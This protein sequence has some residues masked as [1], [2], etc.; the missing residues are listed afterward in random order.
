MRHRW[1][2][3][4]FTLVLFSMI[5]IPAVAS[6]SMTGGCTGSVVIDGVT[7]GPENDTTANPIVVPIDQSGV[8]A[9]WQ[10]AVPFQN[11]ND[12][13]SLGIVLG[14]WTVKVADWGGENPSDERSASGT[15][16]L[17]DFVSELPVSASIIPRGLYELSGSHEADGG[18][19]E[20]NVMVEIRGGLLDGPIGIGTVVGTAVTGLMLIGAA[21]GR[22]P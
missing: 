19:C 11:T 22:R 18:R 3:L 14:P 8:V 17:D 4:M 9:A 5:C 12:H 7:Y 21:F 20:A 15:Y 13:G 6:A 2:P 16:S 1:K 10:G